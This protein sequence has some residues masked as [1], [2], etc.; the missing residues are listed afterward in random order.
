LL[1]PLEF[2]LFILRLFSFGH[3][4][5]L[6]ALFYTFYTV[7]Y[8]YILVSTVLFTVAILPTTFATVHFFIRFCLLFDGTIL[9]VVVLPVHSVH[10][11]FRLAIHLPLF[12]CPTLFVRWFTF[13]RSTISLFTFYLFIVRYLLFTVTTYSFYTRPGVSIFSRSTLRPHFTIPP[14]LTILPPLHSYSDRY[15]M[16]ST[17]TYRYFVYL[18]ITDTRLPHRSMPFYTLLPFTLL[19]FAVPDFSFIVVHFDVSSIPYRSDHRVQ[20]VLP[21]TLFLL[22]CYRCRYHC[23]HTRLHLF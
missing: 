20:P 6:E 7:T 1:L 11:R 23:T 8:R 4:Y 3:F 19:H 14:Y 17:T 22:F 16:H 13:Y 10:L 2:Y 15:V 18:R 5:Q 12:Y 9:F 21:D